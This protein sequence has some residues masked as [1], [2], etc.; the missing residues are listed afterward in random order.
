MNIVANIC[1]LDLTPSHVK[2]QFVRGL[3]N[4]QLQT[5]ILAKANQLKELPQIV[6]HAEAF[7]AAVRN[8]SKLSEHNEE[9]IARIQR[10]EYQP[11]KQIPPQKNTPTHNNKLHLRRTNIC[12]IITLISLLT[13]TPAAS[14][15]NLALAVEVKPIEA[16]RVS[17][18]KKCDAWGQVCN[19]CGIENHFSIVCCKKKIEGVSA[20]QI[21]AVEI[22]HVAYDPPTDSFTSPNK[23][24]KKYQH[25]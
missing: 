4:Q 20:L 5:N 24:Y 11:S 2:D 1:K 13:T 22:A 25:N 8:Q 23:E 9:S 3:S 6:K 19:Y 18:G 14:L 10:S 15:S 16:K 12:T 21:G 17:V 7:E